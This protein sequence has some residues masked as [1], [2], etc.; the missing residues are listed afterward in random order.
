LARFKK[1]PDSGEGPI[2][3]LTEGTGELLG[4]FAINYWPMFLRG[5]PCSC[6][7]CSATSGRPSRSGSPSCCSRP[8]WSSA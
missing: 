4:Q 3:E 1:I 5:S 2:N 8:G 7:S 6:W